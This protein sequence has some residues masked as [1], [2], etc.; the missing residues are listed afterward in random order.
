VKILPNLEISYM[1]MNFSRTTK[2]IFSVTAGIVL[3]GKGLLLTTKAR[4][5][6]TESQRQIIFLSLVWRAAHFLSR[7]NAF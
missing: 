6:G 5:H 7:V 1:C 3:D 2:G 4:G